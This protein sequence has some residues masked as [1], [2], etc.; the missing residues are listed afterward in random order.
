MFPRGREGQASGWGGALTG[1]REK[2]RF[3]QN[4]QRQGAKKPRP[5]VGGGKLKRLVPGWSW[6]GGPGGR[7][8]CATCEQALSMPGGVGRSPPTDLPRS[9][10][11][12]VQSLPH[13]PGDADRKVRLVPCNDLPPPDW[14][15]EQ[16]SPD[17]AFPFQFRK[18]GILPLYRPAKP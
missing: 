6:A 11:P 4:A 18:S 13:D 3:P 15:K 9:V 16:P 7:G 17:L 12:S 2:P 1:G 10:A 5:C 14:R 8:L